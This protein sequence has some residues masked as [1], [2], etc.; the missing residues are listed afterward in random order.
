MPLHAETLVDK[1]FLTVNLGYIDD[2]CARDVQDF[3][4][5]SCGFTSVVLGSF[6]VLN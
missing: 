4:R 2:A 1:I 6:M 5:K 3:G